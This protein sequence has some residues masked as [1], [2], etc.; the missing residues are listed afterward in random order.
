[1]ALEPQPPPYPKRPKLNHSNDLSFENL[2]SLAIHRDRLGDA[3]KVLWRDKGEPI[4]YL[5]TLRQCLDHAVAG[6][7]RSATL[8]FTIRAS[9]NLLLALIKARRIPKSL[10]VA[11]IVFQS[12]PPFR[13]QW[14]ALVR[15][16]IFGQDTFRFAA[17]LGTFAGLYKLLVNSFPIIFPPSPRDLD[18]PL[19][20]ESGLAT[21]G[22][23]RR[24]PRLSLSTQAR[25]ILRQQHG[26]RWHAAV[27]GAIAGGLAL[28]WEKRSRRV[29]F[30]QQLF[31]RG[32]QGIYNDYSEHWGISIP[33]GASIVFALACGQ[34]MYAFFLR[35][36]TL[37]RSYVNWIQEASKASPDSFSYNRQV[38]QESIFDVNALEKVMARA[39]VT[40]SNLVTLQ[41]LRQQ[42]LS[43]D[44]SSIPRYLPCAGL[45]PMSDSCLAV[46][47]TRFLE[48]AQ[49]MLP[50]YAALHFVPTLALR[51]KLFRNNPSKV[52]SHA[53]VGSLRSSAF[54]GAFVTI[55]Q[56][57]W[58]IK[59][60]LYERIM[61]SPA[62]RRVVPQKVTD[63]LISRYTWWIS[64][65]SCGL[66]LFF[67]DERR[68]GELAM[69]TLPKGLESL[70]IVA[71]GRGL[72]GRTGNWGESL[73]AA[74]G[75]GMVMT[76]YQNDP[77]HLSGLVRRILYQFI[78]PN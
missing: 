70:W 9:F 26:R 71:R 12:D 62:L 13:S 42:I 53:T 10:F 33:H 51:W 36:D 63:A 28:M 43:G 64:G 22:L 55:C 37:P 7:A 18:S 47:L 4:I 40:P 73:L 27:A 58:C 1:M 45:H 14:F 75:A 59:H 46:G 39:D 2:V 19:S 54:L 15:H 17:M 77:E 60:R 66:A 16:A 41:S 68:R 24:A 5:S 31:V 50:I 76:I 67:E 20:P 48:V 61:A 29:M 78:G 35:P 25:L 34:I 69:Y 8:G 65:L 32:L 52:L 6:T 57:V 11:F 21:P 49:W 56:A 74:V 38:V 44:H 72:V 23:T 30:A 3:R